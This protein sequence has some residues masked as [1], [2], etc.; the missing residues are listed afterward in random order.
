MSEEQPP[1]GRPAPGAGPVP[2]PAPGAGWSAG[3]SPAPAWGTAA[4]GRPLHQP[5][6]VPLRPLTLTDFFDA[7]FR[8]VRRNP[9]ATVGMGAVV[10]AGFLALPFLVT[11]VLG[12]LGR[13]GGTE[14]FDPYAGGTS[15]G[16]LVY[17]AGSLIS[18]VF[19]ALAG[20]VVA[21]LIVPVVTRSAIGR[22]L[23]IAESWR[24]ARG[25]LL[26]LLALTLLEG[27]V[28][29]VVITVAVVLV[30][31]LALAADQVALAVVLGLLLGLL[32]V[33]GL[34]AVHVKWFR[35]AAPVL[36]AEK[37]G[38]LDSLSR[39]GRLSS[40]HFWR[41]LGTWLLASVAAYFVAQLLTIPLGL[42]GVFAGVAL[43]GSLGT[44]LLL[45][46]GQLSS[47]LV[48]AVVGPFTGAVAVLQYLD[49]RFRKEG[50][51]IE[52]IAWTEQAARDGR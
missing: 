36:V 2:A 29:V 27:L 14:L 18:S 6:T 46:S 20:V 39:A 44:T 34:L 47:V 40:G 48:G 49:L 3:P 43:P 28:A 32:A 4:Y 52:L 22:R 51:D 15:L 17:S 23:T 38:V 13:L 10:T 24:M 5:G 21:G 41:V 16:D 45:V 30:L 9:K 31:V 26:A 8:T 11:V 50:F 35:L 1:P 42:V 7:A 19:S 37:R 25:R 12:L 33:V